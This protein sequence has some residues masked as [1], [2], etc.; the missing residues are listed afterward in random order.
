MLMPLFRDRNANRL[1][2]TLTY[3]ADRSRLHKDEGLINKVP[4]ADSAYNESL[5]KDPT[6][7]WSAVKASMNNVLSV[8]FGTGQGESPVA[9]AMVH[10]ANG[11]N[12]IAATFQAHPWLAQ[13]VGALLL[14]STGLAVLRTMG[15]G[16]R[17]A[18]WPRC[19]ACYSR[20]A[21]APRA[22]RDRR[23]APA[24]PYERLPVHRPAS[25]A[26]RAAA[27]SAALWRWGR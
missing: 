26:V 8:L 10:V 24:R 1:A 17:F 22:D 7:A 15:V 14:G 4:G 21:W 13:G 5:R 20:R 25:P 3:D 9:V 23:L 6:M 19:S 12:M 27:C 2:N 16:L 18:L 11:L